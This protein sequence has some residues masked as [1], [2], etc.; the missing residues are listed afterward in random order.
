MR[1][2]IWWIAFFSAVIYD[3]PIAFGIDYWKVEIPAIVDVTLLMMLGLLLSACAASPRNTPPEY[4]LTAVD[5]TIARTSVV[6]CALI[7]VGMLGEYGTSVFFVHKTDSGISG[8]VYIGWRLSATFALILAVQTRQYRLTWIPAVSLAAT[9]FAGD[10][11]AVGLT[12]I[13][14][15]WLILSSVRLKKA[16]VTIILASF[17]LLG[18][19]LF[20]GKTFQALWWSGHFTTFGAMVDLIVDQGRDSITATEPF[21]TIGVFSA[22]TTLKFGPPGSLLVDICAQLLIIPSYFGF[23]SGSF[24]DYFQSTLFPFYRDR[25]LA[26]SYWGEGYARGGVF[27][28]FGFFAIYLSLLAFFERISRHRK[29]IVRSFAYVGGSYLAFYIHRNS[30]VSIL[31]YQRQI[32]LYVIFVGALAALSRSVYRA[33]R[34]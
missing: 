16:G 6:V 34:R 7:F 14:L 25:S 31:A 5:Q 22:I 10:R 2:N 29:M 24:N 18:T 33:V 1:A 21:T 30:M 23:D 27:G 9:L 11:T 4:T 19:F 32:I 28:I 20:F 15:G 17:A 26:Y 12:A 3:L 13:S 8:L